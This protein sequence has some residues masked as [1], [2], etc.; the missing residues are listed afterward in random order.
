MGRSERTGAVIMILLLAAI[1]LYN[2]FFR[3]V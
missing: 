1:M 3:Q 2:M